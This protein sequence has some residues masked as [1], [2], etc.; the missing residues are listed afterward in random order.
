MKESDL[1]QQRKE[2]LLKESKENQEYLVVGS[3]RRGK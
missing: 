2:C 1:R 3:P